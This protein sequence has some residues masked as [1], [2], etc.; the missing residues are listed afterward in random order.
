MPTSRLTA[1]DR[2]DPA[3]VFEVAFIGGATLTCPLYPADCSWVAIR[4]GDSEPRRI[5]AAAMQADPERE[6]ARLADA[7]SGGRPGIPDLPP[8]EYDGTPADYGTESAVTAVPTGRTLRFASAP[9]PVGY[10]RVCEIDGREVAYWVPD[11]LAEDAA[12]VLGAAV[13]A[14]ASRAVRR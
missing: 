12:D 7:L 4:R 6:L 1:A 13:G 10:L 5:D 8:T 9:D 2:S 11:E 3:E 14:V